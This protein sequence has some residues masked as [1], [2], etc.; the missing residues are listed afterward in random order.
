[1]VSCRA[2][3]P[4]DFSGACQ[5]CRAAGSGICQSCRVPLI[6]TTMPTSGAPG[7]ARW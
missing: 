4:D 2:D 5:A 3:V 6:P 1:M 7:G